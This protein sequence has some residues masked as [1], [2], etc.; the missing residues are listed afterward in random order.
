V[1]RCLQWQHERRPCPRWGAQGAV[2]A[3]HGAAVFAR[4]VA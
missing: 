1:W 4:D 3:L 2:R